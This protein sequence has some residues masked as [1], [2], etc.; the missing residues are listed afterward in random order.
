MCK[1][2]NDERV[3]LLLVEDQA[4]IAMQEE[5]MLRNA[6]Y[7]VITASSGEKAISIVEDASPDDSIDLILMDID[8]GKGMDGTEAAGVIL[9]S[10]DIP[11]LFLSGHTEDDIVKKTEEIT[12]YGYVVKGSGP[13]V[14]L[15]S[16]KMALRLHASER[17][18]QSVLSHVQEVSVQG[19]DKDG[20]TKY[21]NDAS[22][23]VYG[24]TAE[25][26]LGRKLWDLIIPKEMV[27]EVKDLVNQM[28]TTGTPNPPE[29]LSLRHKK[30]HPVLVRSSHSVTY[31]VSGN[32]ELF[33]VDILLNSEG[34]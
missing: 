20:T 6:G 2:V 29:T 30:G 4:I 8:L 33:C 21:W 3:I 25:E 27:S 11:I 7:E 19:Y 31:D 9:R 18:F 12:S 24:Y 14:I 10:H 1:K 26:A 15:A 34:D 16:I 13:V 28:V 17:R 5:R 32:P 23:F 22:E